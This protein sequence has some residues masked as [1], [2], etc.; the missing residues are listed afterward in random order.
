[1]IMKI[2]IIYNSFS[3]QYTYEETSG[4]DEE[5]F[6]IESNQYSETEEITHDNYVSEKKDYYDESKES[7]YSED[8][9]EYNYEDEYTHYE[10]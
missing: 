4:N 1:M 3:E 7:D 5:S 6:N 10:E 9:H 8:N 2:I